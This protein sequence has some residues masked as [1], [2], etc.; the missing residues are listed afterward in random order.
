MNNERIASQFDELADLLEI[1]GA[2]P[3]RIELTATLPELWKA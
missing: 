3:F 1:Q 2:N